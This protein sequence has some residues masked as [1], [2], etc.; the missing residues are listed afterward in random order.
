MTVDIQALLAHNAKVYIA[1]R[2][3]TK[4]KT[5]IDKLKADTGGKEAH[6]IQLDLSDL[7]KVKKAAEDFQGKETSLHLLFLNAYGSFFPF[8]KGPNT[9]V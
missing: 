7:N 1:G 3:P 9:A 6:S 4:I 2:D 8:S 5:A